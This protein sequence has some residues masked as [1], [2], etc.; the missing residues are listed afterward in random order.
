VRLGRG[1]CAHMG[2]DGVTPSTT[3]DRYVTPLARSSPI[4]SGATASC[5]ASSVSPPHPPPCSG[6]CRPESW[7]PPPRST[8]A[9]TPSA[10][11]SDLCGRGR[12]SQGM[13]LHVTQRHARLGDRPP[14][15]SAVGRRTIRSRRHMTPPTPDERVRDGVRTG[16]HRGIPRHSRRCPFDEADLD[17]MPKGLAPQGACIK[18]RRSTT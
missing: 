11:A 8:A 16:R 15:R 9:R 18:R 1:H 13:F 4:H 5:A 12:A 6:N 17:G 7:P 3:W 2:D 10:R 14:R